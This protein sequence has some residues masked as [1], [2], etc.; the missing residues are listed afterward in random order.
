MTESGFADKAAFLQA[1]RRVPEEVVDTAAGKVR[2]VGMTA[3]ERS[4]FERSMQNVKGKPIQSRV[5]ET[6]ERLVVATARTGDGS[7]LFTAEDIAE[8]SKAAAAVL[9]P[10]VNAAMRVC[11]MNES[12]VEDMAKNSSGTTDS[13]G[14]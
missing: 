14:G 3:A 7:P 2:V 12:D 4:A 5:Q 10:L 6:R 1:A 11:G 9:E 8:L 13:A